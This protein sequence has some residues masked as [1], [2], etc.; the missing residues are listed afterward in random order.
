MGG[1][2]GRPAYADVAVV[3]D[4]IVDMSVPGRQSTRS[5]PTSPAWS[6]GDLG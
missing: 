1:F 4:R 6:L 2:H 3:R 5:S